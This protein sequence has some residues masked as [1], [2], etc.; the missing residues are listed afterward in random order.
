[1]LPLQRLRTVDPESSVADA[2]ETMAREDVHQLPVMADGRLMGIIGRGDVIRVL[3]VREELGREQ[4]PT[5]PGQ[6]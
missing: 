1:M 2:L 3:K 5:P 4:G 6:R